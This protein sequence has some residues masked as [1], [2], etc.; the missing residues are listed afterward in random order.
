M[1]DPRA[2]MF[3]VRADSVG[4]GNE[5][6]LKRNSDTVLV[7]QVH[8][9]HARRSVEI[10]IESLGEPQ[11]TGWCGLEVCCSLGRARRGL[12]AAPAR[13]PGGLAP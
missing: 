2:M 4:V 8:R 9:G 11:L 6:R 13:D 5:Q 12:V 1:R 10:A 3:D 7:A